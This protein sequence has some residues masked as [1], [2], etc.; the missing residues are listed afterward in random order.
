MGL[1]LN[2]IDT[3]ILIGVA[4][5]TGSGKTTLCKRFIKQSGLD[6]GLICHD[7]YYKDLSHLPVKERDH[8]NF[9]HPDAIDN[10]L[11]CSHLEDLKR[12]RSIKIP[13]YDFATHT[14]TG[15]SVDFYPADIILIEGIMLFCD[16]RMGELFDY[17]IYL[18]LD[19]DVRFI[20]RL[21]RDIDERGRSMNSV[22]EQYLG[23]VKPMYIKFVDPTKNSA[24]VIINGDDSQSFIKRIENFFNSLQ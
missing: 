6:A 2:M 19:S 20:R 21:K 5:G 8:R 4:G 11:F 23:T 9:D 16:V 24:D 10:D 18:E 13:E 1:R 3:P 12:K 14:R 7:S 22:I 15:R 17:K